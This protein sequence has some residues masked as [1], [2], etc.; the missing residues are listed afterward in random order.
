[1]AING[2]RQNHGDGSRAGSIS[3]S[4]MALLILGIIMLCGCGIHRVAVS[5]RSQIGFVAVVDPSYGPAAID[6]LKQSLSTAPYIETITGRTAAE[7]LRRWEELMGPEELLDINP[8]LPEF[9]ITVKPEWARADSL[10][11]IA[12]NLESLSCVDHVQIHADTASAVGRHTA[13]LFLALS[14]AALGIA[15]CCI[16]LISNATIARLRS[17]S[18]LVV[19]RLLLGDRRS[20]IASWLTLREAIDSVIASLAAATALTALWAYAGFLDS[21]VAA[22]IPWTCLAAVAAALLL[23]SVTVSA[24][25]AFMWVNIRI[26]R[27]HNGDDD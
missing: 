24:V 11:S 8:F 12:L 20:S 19:D 10:E 7:V 25:T 18:E 9:D 23:T 15:A 3:A 26:S 27:L 1:M 14:L 13:S 21:N 16:A 22:T 5:V 4:A 6:S 17:L 2:T